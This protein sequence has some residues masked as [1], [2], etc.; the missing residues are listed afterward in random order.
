MVILRDSEYN[1]Q[2]TQAT[3][4]ED[5]VERIMRRGNYLCDGETHLHWLMTRRHPHF[6]SETKQK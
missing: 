2:I 4:T 5:E 6:H 1:V 3:T